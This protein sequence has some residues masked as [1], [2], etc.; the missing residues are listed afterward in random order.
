MAGVKTKPLLPTWWLVAAAW[1]IVVILVGGTGP[2]QGKGWPPITGDD[3]WRLVEAQDLANGQAWTDT[4]QYRDNTPYGSPMHWSRLVDAPLAALAIAFRPVFGSEASLAAASA[5]PLLL[6]IPFLILVVALAERMA[7]T[8]ARLPALIVT[9]LAFPTYS[10]FSGGRVDHHNVQMVLVLALMLA[11]VNGRTSRVAAAVAG[12]VA[13]TGLAIGMECLPAVLAALALFPLFW[14]MDPK[15]GRG[16]ALA[17]AVSF[18]LALLGHLLLVTDPGK[19]LIAACDALSITYVAAGLFYAAVVVGVVFVGSAIR[20]PWLRFGLMAGAG[21]VAAGATL[22]IYPECL[23]GPYGALDKDLAH[24]LLTDISEAMPIWRWLENVA[25]GAAGLMIVPLMGLIG[26][27]AAA[28][29]ARGEKRLDW[30]VIAAFAILLAAVVVMQVRGLRLAI[31]PAFPVGGAGIATLWAEFRVR[32]N[33]WALSGLAAGVLAFA[34]AAHVVGMFLFFP[35]PKAVPA[36]SAAYKQCL[37]PNEY[38]NLAALPEGRIASYLLMGP[39]LLLWTPHS[40]VSAGYHRGE[41]GMRDALTFVSSDEATALGIA[42]AR[43]LDYFV[44]C[45][46][47][48]L[49][50]G[51]YDLP[52]FQGIT[53]AGVQWPWLRALSTPEEAVQVYA[54]DLPAN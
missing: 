22:A 4:T 16:P 3:A 13:A 47:V 33:A 23:A 37:K 26:A 28:W 38:T 9:L 15:A 43:S 29:L 11:T 34:G 46:G 8:G 19:L 32:R 27:I 30:L 45:R 51:L 44:F 2:F 48:P 52:D 25:G 6:L 54:I 24:I 50:S 1:L 41:E 49:N 14:V 10:E 36:T 17:F 20:V 42:R 5:W 53:E 31:L 12:L 7:G 39:S 18:G 35:S 40:I 21:I